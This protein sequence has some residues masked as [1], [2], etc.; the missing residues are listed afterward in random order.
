MNT[1]KLCNVPLKDFRN[2]LSKAGCNFSGTE[3]GY[4]K[5]TRKD[6]TRP[7]TVQI[8]MSQLWTM[9]ILVIAVVVENIRIVTEKY[10]FPIKKELCR[11]P[12]INMP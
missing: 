1:N 6:L 8:K 7:I 12:P 2:F 5:W 3:G 9:R 4:E 10:N 11:K